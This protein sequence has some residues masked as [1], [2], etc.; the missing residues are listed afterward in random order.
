MQPYCLRQ[1]IGAVGRFNSPSIHM[2]VLACR[3]L[4][5]ID[6]KV[7]DTSD[8]MCASQ[9]TDLRMLKSYYPRDFYK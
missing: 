5:P 3:E 1:R 2:H 8:N 6:D 7:F 9:S 4:L